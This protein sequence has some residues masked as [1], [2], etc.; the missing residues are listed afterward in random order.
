MP[1]GT[2]ESLLSHDLVW[3]VKTQSV[4]HTKKVCFFF[5]SEKVWFCKE[6]F[7][8][9]STKILCLTKGRHAF[10]VILYRFEYICALYPFYLNL[11]TPF[12]RFGFLINEIF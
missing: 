2:F 8:S 4:T 1:N 3:F 12:V 11:I 6:D 7:I 5:S 10:C 9:L